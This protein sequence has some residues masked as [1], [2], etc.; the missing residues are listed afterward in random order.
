MGSAPN[1]T[2]AL[3]AALATEHYIRNAVKNGDK[4]YIENPTGQL[5]ELVFK[6]TESP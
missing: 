1:V 5:R 2:Q 6:T 3:R 4:V